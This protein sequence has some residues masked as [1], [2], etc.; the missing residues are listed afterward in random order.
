MKKF[1][2]TLEREKTELKNRLNVIDKAIDSVQKVCKH[3]LDNGK[4]AKEII[5]NDSHKTHYKCS[6]CG[7]EDK[8]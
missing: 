7:W 5:G 6:I 4:T 3:K 8:Y 1:I 2:E